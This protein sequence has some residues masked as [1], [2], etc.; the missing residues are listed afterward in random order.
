MSGASVW[1]ASVSET[2][3]AFRF[4][5]KAENLAKKLAP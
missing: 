5:D 4:L 2:L 3:R 1:G